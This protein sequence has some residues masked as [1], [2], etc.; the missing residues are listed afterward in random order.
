MAR[1]A[2]K[3]R[4]QARRER[5]RLR[6]TRAR[7]KFWNVYG[8]YWGVR[9]EIAN[10][11][12]LAGLVI[13]A[14]A[15]LAGPAAPVAG[16]V[17]TAAIGIDTKLAPEMRELAGSQEAIALTLIEEL[18]ADGQITEAEAERLAKQTIDI[19]ETPAEEKQTRGRR[20][21]FSAI[22]RGP[23]RQTSTGG[24]PIADTGP[25]IEPWQIAAAAALLFLVLR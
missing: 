3:A 6:W 1:G 4:R 10:D 22:A 17:A 7:A 18:E 25:T 12:K 16:G 13:A 11:P 8:R 15:L 23:G 5:L 21:N 20:R 2:G 19:L 24:T 14:V 9:E